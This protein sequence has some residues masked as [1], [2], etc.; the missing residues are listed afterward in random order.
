MDKL[1][2]DDGCP[3]DRVQTHESLR[4]YLMEECYEAIDAVN[5][6]DMTALC[7]ELGDILL[8]VV[9]HSKIGEKL[10]QF[11]IDD[12]I[13]NISK[14]MINRHRHIFGG[15]K[16]DTPEEVADS[17]EK[18]KNEEKGYQ[19]IAEKINSV[20]K[21][22]PSLLRAEKIQKRSGLDEH[23]TRKDADNVSTLLNTILKSTNSYESERRQDKTF[24][25]EQIGML[26]FY[27]VQICRFFRI[28]PEFALTNALET[29]ITRFK[30]GETTMDV[31]GLM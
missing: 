21:A 29:Y 12:V 26:L 19:T 8:E 9:F 16:A 22:L 15:E 2:S 17:W 5:N 1:L 13:D 7:E 3:W 27:V 4:Q 24:I 25:E 11:T 6:N 14:K 28:N 18:I 23:I 31:C 10:N 20:P 30:N